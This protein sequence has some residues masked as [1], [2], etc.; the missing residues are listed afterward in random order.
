MNQPLISIQWIELKSTDNGILKTMPATLNVPFDYTVFQALIAIGFKE[1][2]VQKW[3]QN[4]AIAV[5]GQYA[6]ANT[7][8]YEGDRI[9]ILD[10]LNFDPMESRRRRAAHRMQQKQENGK[11]ARKSVANPL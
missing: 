8:L 7:A 1:D 3:L 6:L 11:P 9:E 5:F 4:R 10:D 2:R